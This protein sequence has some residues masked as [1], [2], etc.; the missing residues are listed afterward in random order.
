M[1]ENQLPTSHALEYIYITD[2]QNLLLR[3]SALL[4]CHHQGVF[5]V[6][7]VVLSKWSAVCS[8]VTRLHKYYTFVFDVHRAVHHNIFL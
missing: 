5:A 6:V 4:G 2:A 8:T 1:L 3:V 7:K